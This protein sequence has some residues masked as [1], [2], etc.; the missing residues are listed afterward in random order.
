LEFEIK[1]EKL[2]KTAELVIKLKEQLKEKD[3]IINELMRKLAKH[4][5]DTGDIN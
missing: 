3:V 4:E 1:I 2:K 5:R